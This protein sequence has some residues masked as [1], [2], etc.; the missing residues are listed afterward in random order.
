MDACLPPLEILI[1]LIWG[2]TW[3]GGRRFLVVL[4]VWFLDP[5]L[6]VTLELAC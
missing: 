5:Q 6:S 4:K 3:V 2:V 1:Q